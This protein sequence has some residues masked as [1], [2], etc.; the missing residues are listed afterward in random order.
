MFFYYKELIMNVINIQKINRQNNGIALVAVL[1]ILVVLALL[2]ASF[3]A[4]M[5][6]EQQSANTT[7]ASV[8]ADL[9]AKAGLEHAISL[10]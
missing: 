1:A 6:I 10:L 4:L 8:Q 7:V 9:C 5:S 2:A 3:S